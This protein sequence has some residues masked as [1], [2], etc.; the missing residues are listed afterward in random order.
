MGCRRASYLASYIASSYKQ[1][2]DNRLQK[3]GNHHQQAVMKRMETHLQHVDW[4]LWGDDDV[5]E[6]LFLMLSIEE[7]LEVVK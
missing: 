3:G 1:G 5:L 6:R 2:G 4:W 7:G